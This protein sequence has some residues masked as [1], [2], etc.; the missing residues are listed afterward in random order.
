MHTVDCQCLA[1]PRSSLEL[2]VDNHLSSIRHA[3]HLI[4]IQCYR[5]KSAIET[6]IVYH[7]TTR[8]LWRSIRRDTSALCADR[9]KRS[10][11]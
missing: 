8:T 9:D 11:Y 4:S 7:H 1:I 6:K 2:F 10:G 3:L 5:D